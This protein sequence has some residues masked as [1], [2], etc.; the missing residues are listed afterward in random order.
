[1]KAKPKPKLPQK[2]GRGHGRDAAMLSVRMN[3]EEAAMLKELQ[4][5]WYAEGGPVFRRAMVEAHK[6]EF[7]K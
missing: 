4:A 7:G 2:P 6:R 5:K 1:M 3:A